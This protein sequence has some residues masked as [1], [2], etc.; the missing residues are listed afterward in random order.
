MKLSK[1]TKE[2]LELLSYTKIAKMYLEENKKTM[3]TAD[4][5]REI[6]NLLDLSEAEYQDKIA[7]FFE[8][9]TTSKDFI[10]LNDGNWDLKVNHQIKIDIDE[11]YEEKDDEIDEYESLEEIEEESDEEPEEELDDYDSIQDDDFDDDELSDLTIVN[12]EELE[13]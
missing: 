13:D 4:L 2:D 1:M 6:C 10:L 12:E 11:I 7:D 9:L 8:S 5:F 3:N